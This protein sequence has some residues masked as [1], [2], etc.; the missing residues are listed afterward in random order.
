MQAKVDTNGD[1]ARINWLRL[2][3][4]HMSALACILRRL[5]WLALI[6]SVAIYFGL[7]QTGWQLGGSVVNHMTEESALWLA[8]GL[9]IGSVLAVLSVGV[10]IYW[11]ER[12]YGSAADFDT[13]MVLAI[14]ISSPIMLAGFVLFWPQLTLVVLA[15]FAGMCLAV[16]LMFTGVPIMME[17]PE[18]S[19]VLYSVSILTVALCVFVG[20]MMTMVIIFSSWVPLTII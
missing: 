18:N 20:A 13:S 15:Y 3:N 19:G 11:M 1:I 6:P 17:V 16:Y 2:H 9:Y 4:R 14:Y 8:A 5:S 7:S 10:A 12:T